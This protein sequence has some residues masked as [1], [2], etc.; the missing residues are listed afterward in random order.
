LN[1]KT[2]RVYDEPSKDDGIRIL[3][4]RLWPRGMKKERLGAAWV[5]EVAPSTELRK[6]FKHETPKWMEFK[7]RYFQ[8]LD[9]NPDAVDELRKAIGKG[10]ATLLFA[11]QDTE[12]NHALALVEYLNRTE[13]VKRPR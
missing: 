13:D 6:W 7:R 4:D 11:A 1:I 3:V 12:Q 9:E 8:E 5:K 2:K 10:T